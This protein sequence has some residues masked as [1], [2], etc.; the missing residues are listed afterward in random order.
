MSKLVFENRTCSIAAQLTWSVFEGSPKSRRDVRK[1]A[2]VVSAFK[3]IVVDQGDHNRIGLA[4]GDGLDGRI[5]KAKRLNSFALLCN[6]FLHDSDDEAPTRNGIFVMVPETDEARR[7]VCVIRNSDIV[8]DVV[9][10]VERVFEIVQERHGE[11]GGHCQVFAERDELPVGLTTQ[12]TWENLAAYAD[13]SNTMTA[14]PGSPLVFAGVMFGVLALGSAVAYWYMVEVPRREEERLRK[15][16][17]ADKTPQYLKALR[18]AAQSTGWTRDSMRKAIEGLGKRPYL[19]PAGWRLSSVRCDTQVCTESW[20]REGGDINGLVAE[21]RVAQLQADA[22]LRPDSATMT[23]APIVEPS[24][25][26]LATLPHGAEELQKALKPVMQRLD[27]VEVR[28]SLG[29]PTAWPPTAPTGGVKKNVIVTAQPVKVV[30]AYPLGSEVLGKLPANV[31]FNGFTLELTNPR[32]FT[33]T[34]E[35]NSYAH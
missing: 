27:N 28:V 5:Q 29:K 18:A 4:T 21:H 1:T 14:V 22:K 30:S 19:L 7:C 11:F 31:V 3:Y 12:I 35:G 23:W 13:K 6:A 32:T 9:E 15:L 2:V 24:K 8:L 34:I 26:D 33:L 20:A 10:S 17:E 25:V 16:A